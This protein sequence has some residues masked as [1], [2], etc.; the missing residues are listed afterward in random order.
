M[1]EQ[2]PEL[3]VD[4][5]VVQ[6]CMLRWQGQPCNLKHMT[7]SIAKGCSDV[8]CCWQLLAGSEQTA[9]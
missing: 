8:A 4:V 3:Q 9:A 6:A 7:I 1:A 2:L 5:S